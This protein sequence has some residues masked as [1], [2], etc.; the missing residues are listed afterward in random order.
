MGTDGA[1][2]WRRGVEDLYHYR[3]W[4]QV[5]RW[6]A[7]Q[8]NM[9]QGDSMRLFYA[10]DRPEAGNVL[11]LNV[12]VMS[13]TGEPL[14]SGTVVVQSM[15]PSGQTDSIR[16]AP[17]GE[18]AWGLFT[19]TFLPTEGGPYRLLTSCAETGA[20][21]ETTIA[22]QGGEKEQIGQPARSDVLKE[23]A[24]VTRGELT[25][26][27]Q[28]PQLVERLAALPEPE[29]IIRRFRLWSHPGWGGLLVMLLGAFWTSRKLAGLA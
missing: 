2:R 8:R 11:T 23:I 29:P 1:W 14:R 17:G 27:G 5:V 16:L 18:D 22:V 24:Q 12:N 13:T 21:L 10:P 20:T 15:S 6:M 7:Y 4:G 9:S 19:G 25:S 28:I 26:L 3:F